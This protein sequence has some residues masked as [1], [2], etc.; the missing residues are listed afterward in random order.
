MSTLVGLGLTAAYLLPVA[1]LALVLTSEARGRR[2]LI[3]SALAALP[4]FY[5]GH[6]LLMQEVQGWPSD[7]PLPDDFRLV[8]F[9]ISEPDPGTEAAGQILL[10]VRS[11]DQQHPRVHRL[12]YERNLHQELVAAG[13]R[14]AEGNPQRGSRSPQAPSAAPGPRNHARASLTFEDETRRALPAKPSPP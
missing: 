8:A 11:A 6:Y 7:A 9:D 13:R 10:W 3:T 5:V 1:L 12:A 2:W 14:Q 4:I